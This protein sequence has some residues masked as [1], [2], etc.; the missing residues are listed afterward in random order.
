M[1]EV[2]RFLDKFGGTVHTCPPPPLSRR[3]RVHLCNSQIVIMSVERL[4]RISPSPTGR[5]LG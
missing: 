4:L 3:E 1:L 2:Y 5:G